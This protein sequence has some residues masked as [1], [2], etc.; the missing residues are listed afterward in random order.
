M[1]RTGGKRRGSEVGLSLGEVTSSET[2]LEKAVG[3][4][5]QFC[6][7]FPALPRG[8]GGGQ[9][10][11]SVVSVETSAPTIC[12]SNQFIFSLLLSF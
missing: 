8:G 1:E 6:L 3:G 12:S 4:E 11:P 5:R 10:S 7:L 9:A 2:V